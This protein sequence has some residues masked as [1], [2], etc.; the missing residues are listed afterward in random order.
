MD[1]P[2][3]YVDIADRKWWLGSKVISVNS[4]GSMRYMR[5]FTDKAVV[6]CRKDNLGVEV[7]KALKMVES[8]VKQYGIED[9]EVVLNTRPGDDKCY[10]SEESWDMAVDVLNEALNMKYWQ[11]SVRKSDEAYKGSTLGPS[12]D[13]TMRDYNQREL[14]TSTILVDF[15]FAD[16]CTLEYLNGDGTTSQPLV[17]HL[18][19]A[20]WYGL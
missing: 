1:L 18:I 12:I 11:F 15:G 2:I 20:F 6:F 8:V 13:V 14:Q 5:T 19:D 4:Y 7:T 10:E 9:Y 3:N 17:L 16:D